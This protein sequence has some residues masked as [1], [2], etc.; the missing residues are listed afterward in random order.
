[1][2]ISLDGRGVLR[3]GGEDRR[4]FLQGLLT[5]NM[6]K[7][8]QNK[9]LYAALLNPQGRFFQDFFITQDDTSLY[10]ECERAM[11][12]DVMTLLTR[13]KLRA[14]VDLED[15]SHTRWVYGWLGDK[16]PTVQD[17]LQ[18]LYPDP[19]TPKMGW[20]AITT[21][22]WSTSLSFELYDLARLKLGLPDGTRDM[23]PGRAIVL[24][25]GLDK[26]GAV[27]YEKGC[28]LGQELTARTHYT[29][30][31]RKGIFP[32]S[33]DGD[34]PEYK[35][36]V[37]QAGEEVGEM[38]SSCAP[39]EGPSWGLVRLRLA[40]LEKDE[41]LWCAGVLLNLHTLK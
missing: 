22:P 6:D 16:E 1:M 25:Y 13:Y 21:K 36:P 8:D 10:L 4:R 15:L 9:A 20:R 12:G 28:Y 38:L 26:I 11:M 32:V 40:A 39:Q 17:G 5:Q 19:R 3:V 14:R 29:G 23:E 35:A 37:T 30:I 27:D 2:W 31:L 18:I 34:L 41:P 7:L 33:F 24:E